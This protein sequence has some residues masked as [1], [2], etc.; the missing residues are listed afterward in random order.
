[1]DS[2]DYIT[3]STLK[4]IDSDEEFQE[5]DNVIVKTTNG[6]VFQ[7]QISDITS[8]EI[9]LSLSGNVDGDVTI[10]YEHIKSI[11]RED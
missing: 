5:D 1:M 3:L 4:L 11:E 8:R 2:C 7:G 6:S 9:S 10:E